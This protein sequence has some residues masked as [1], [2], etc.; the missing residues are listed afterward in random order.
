MCGVAGF[1]F[2]HR[3]MDDA[4]RV[5]S[6][7]AE[8]LRHRGPDDAGSW[9][10]EAAGVAIGHRR[11]SIIDLSMDG[12][13]P[14]I[15]HSG[16]YV[17]A[18]NGEVYNFLELREELAGGGTQFRGGSDT[19]VMLA[20]VEAW[21]LEAA[22]RR[23]VGM[24]AFALWDRQEKTLCLARDRIGEKPLYY[25]WCGKCFLFGSELKALRAHP[26]WEGEISTRALV[27][28][29]KR[30]YVP[31]PHS[32]YRGIRKLAPGAILRLRTSDA[33]GHL[34]EPS[35]YW[36][37]QE[38]IQD[39]LP[40]RRAP[41]DDEAIDQLDK[42]LRRSVRQCLRAD[43]PVGAFLSGGIDSSL[44]VALMQAESSA[45]ARTF[46]IG[47]HEA[48]Y[49]EARHAAEVARHLQTDHS[50]LYVSPK[51]ALQVIPHLPQLYDEPFADSSQIPTSLVAALAREHVTVSLSGDG[52]DELFGGYNR[53]N[54]V[55]AMWNASRWLP[56]WSRKCAARGLL[57][58]RPALANFYQKLSPMLPMRYRFE[59][60]EEKIQKLGRLLRT[61]RLDEVYENLRTHWADTCVRQDRHLEGSL[62]PD[63]VPDGLHSAEQMMYRDLRDYLPDDL[64]VKVDRASMGVGLEVRAPYLD[65]RVV[66]FAWGLP[67]GYKVRKSEGK[68]IL[69]RLLS[70]Y[71]PASLTE[72]PKSGFYMPIGV[73]LRGTLRDWAED[74]LEES[75]LVREGF[76]QAKP[77]RRIWEHHLAGK[78]NWES[79][80]W[81]ILMFQSWQ[82]AQRK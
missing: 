15:S 11:L 75:R 25:G 13:Q 77:I 53:H 70:R 37:A 59:M 64:L 55:I 17:I 79:A 58:W 69:K 80:L 7:M 81:C 44:L 49:N 46:S 51:E 39:A 71:V 41:S 50:E 29:T 20:A 40:N 57:A 43:V 62:S 36:C 73:W 16:R 56:E 4:R 82:D 32:I 42:A 9:V 74:L 47:F 72:R 67:L 65:H 14:M 30:G 5:V 31:C 35:A 8:C 3:E 22:V 21:G 24:F 60:S 1:L 2:T 68:W 52:G 33:P 66:E 19:E 54:R 27:W 34:P 61:S 63:P 28:Y 23:F 26:D 48:G 12:H 10:D 45:T 38:V 18:Y 6:R 76:F 78:G